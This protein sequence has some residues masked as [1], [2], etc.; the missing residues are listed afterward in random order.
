ME[1]K[2]KTK[3]FSNVF[4]TS[5][6]INSKLP[7]EILEILSQHELWLK[8][9][10]KNGKKANFK[11]N[12]LN[13]LKINGFD[14]RKANFK[15]I[16]LMN[17]N[18]DNSNLSESE[19]DNSTLT[20]VSFIKS[21]LEKASFFDSKLNKVEF[22][23][24]NLVES[25]FQYA[26]LKNVNFS[27]ANLSKAEM[28]DIVLKDINLKYANLED[29]TLSNVPLDQIN[30]DNV[31]L[32]GTIGTEDYLEE[33]TN[34]LRNRNIHLEKENLELKDENFSLREE[35][36]R[37]LVESF[38]EIK[39]EYKTE[40]RGW[41]AVVIS[42]ILIMCV[43]FGLALFQG[44]MTEYEKFTQSFITIPLG[45]F[46]FS[47]F[48]FFIYQYSKIKNLRIESL[49]KIATAKGYLGLL[50]MNEDQSRINLFLDN[51]SQVLFSKTK[52]F[53]EK[54]L[55]IDEL[56]RLINLNSRKGLNEEE[57]KK[58]IKISSEYKEKNN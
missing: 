31:N 11:K 47:I 7:E 43:L 42:M 13:N 29:T 56:T 46:L 32:F 2:L 26:N 35:N 3:T 44:K 57:I 19:F 16:T 54:V 20:S 33:F 28:S 21:N 17:T 23:N 45:F 49:N 25:N 38:E 51:I 48:Y 53:R 8:G 9:D 18:F 14:L 55:P 12:N 58:I 50:A 36:T 37:K 10:K 24:S 52:D 30:L 27:K 4:A 6:I 15:D 39:D 5:K 40:E 41:L 1:K 34:S 22:Q